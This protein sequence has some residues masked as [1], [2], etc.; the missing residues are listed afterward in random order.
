MPFLCAWEILEQ[1]AMFAVNAT[2][3]EGD[4]EEAGRHLR[5]FS[6]MYTILYDNSDLF[7]R[8]QRPNEA[9]NLIKLLENKLFPWLNFKHN[10]L[11]DLR[12]TWNGRGIVMA[13]GKWH[14]P[15]AIHAILSLRVLLN[16][17]LPI[18]LFH[19]GSDDIEPN[20]KRIYEKIPNVKVV[21]INNYF[22]L[23]STNTQIHG[24][25]TKPYTMLASRFKEMIFIDADS[26]FLQSPEILYDFEGYKKTGTTFFYDRTVNRGEQDTHRWFKSWMKD[27][28]II[29]LTTRFYN[30]KTLHEMDSGVVLFDKERAYLHLLGAC[31]LN[32]H[33]DR[34]FA[35]RNIHGDKETFW[36]MAE[37]LRLPYSF[38][39]PYGGVIGYQEDG[40]ICGG[41]LH[42][43]EQEK[44]FWWN[45]GVL[46]NK[47]VHRDRYYDFTH[48]AF[49]RTSN[50]G[51]KWDNDDKPFCMTPMDSANSA[52][53]LNE[54]D[55]LLA[56]QMVELD[57]K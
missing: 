16:V 4:Y 57:R 32:T 39:G 53:T 18:E 46:V 28:S 2:W 35:M 47:R 26:L 54:H 8:I 21:D 38:R 19:K 50:V 5:T 27:P 9:K 34:E 30:H 22:N 33:Q 41:L 3:R 56:K 13:A 55:K 42:G 52:V 12:K 23:D 11:Q 45:G 17:T 51:W 37:L 25:F 31:W 7:S 15:F 43:D 49:D 14:F 10:S 44:P 36:M 24:W 48:F 29:G 20:M 6:Q 40:E 1:H